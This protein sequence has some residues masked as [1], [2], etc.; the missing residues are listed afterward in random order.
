[1]ND[2]SS[3][4]GSVGTRSEH[5]DA[6]GSTNSAPMRLLHGDGAERQLEPQ[7]DCETDN[8]SS[9]VSSACGSAVRGAATVVMLIVQQLPVMMWFLAWLLKQKLMH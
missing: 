1:M 9:A 6:D 2:D 4:S 8:D 7:D 3:N 5:D